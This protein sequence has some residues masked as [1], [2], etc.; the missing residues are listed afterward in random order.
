MCVE[1]FVLLG[2]SD[3]HKTVASPE[4]FLEVFMCLCASFS[5]NSE[6]GISIIEQVF[7]GTVV[8]SVVMSVNAL[9]PCGESE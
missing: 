5:E 8:E 6:R 2:L 9:K 4:R 3:I 7:A 1:L